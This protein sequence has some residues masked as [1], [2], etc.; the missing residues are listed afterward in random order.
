MYKRQGFYSSQNQRIDAPTTA[1]WLPGTSNQILLQVP[2]AWDVLQL[3]AQGE[4]SFSHPWEDR[5][6]GVFIRHIF[7][8]RTWLVEEIDEDGNRMVCKWSAGSPAHSQE[9]DSLV[10][11]IPAP[12]IAHSGD[13]EAK[14]LPNNTIR[15]LNQETSFL[16]TPPRPISIYQ[17]L[18]VDGGERLLAVGVDHRIVEWNLPQLEQELHQRGFQ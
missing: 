3:D 6:P 16:L 14:V 1:W 10:E 7:P 5:V 13:L 18:F 4:L 9:V 2:G 11:E 12:L 15:I 8:D 17:I